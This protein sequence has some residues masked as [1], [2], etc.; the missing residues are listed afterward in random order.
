MNFREFLKKEKLLT[1]FKSNFQRRKELWAEQLYVRIF[2]FYPFKE[3]DLH[4]MS[5]ERYLKE[6]EDEITI[7]T[8]AFYWKDSPEGFGFWRNINAKWITYLQK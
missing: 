4:N 6:Y 3:I 8:N 7:L 2:L 5:P 1:K